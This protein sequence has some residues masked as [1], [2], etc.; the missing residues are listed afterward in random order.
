MKIIVYGL[1]II[2][3][4]VCASLRAAGHAVYGRNRSRRPIEYAL[5]HGYIDGEAETYEGADVVIIALPPR[6]ALKELDEGDFPDGC[7]VSDIC[8]VKR[9]LEDAV[10]AKPRGYRYVGIHPMAG[11]ETSGIE[12]ASADLFQGANLVIAVNEDTDKDALETVRRLAGDM[13]FAHIAECSAEKHDRMI[14]L[15]SQLAHVVS[16]A[17]VKSPD[18]LGCDGF[19]GGSFQDMTRVAGVDENVWTELYF[20]NREPLLSEI[21]RIEARLEEYRAALSAG[22]EDRMRE[23]I[24]EG[25]QYR[26]LIFSGKKG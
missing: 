6:A 11:K 9:L 8:G 5:E 7:I 14:A 21:E 13:G 20:S 2:G 17:Y 22:D 4:S 19:T 3:A 16:S 10:K 12:S 23:L 18:A 25:K 15:T 24:G 1:G 26:G